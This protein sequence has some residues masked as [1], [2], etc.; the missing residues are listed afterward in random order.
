M[1]LFFLLG[2]G[3]DLSGE[4]I[5]SST[6]MSVPCESYVIEDMTYYR[7]VLEGL[8]PTEISD[9]KLCANRSDDIFAYSCFLDLH[10]AYIGE[11]TVVHCGGLWTLSQYHSDFEFTNLTIY[12]REER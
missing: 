9:V 3:E 5:P 12:Y 11:D 6:L 1:V 8:H 2:C 7:A 10:L 4:D